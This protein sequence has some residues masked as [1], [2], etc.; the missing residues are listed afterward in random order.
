MH[1][2]SREQMRSA[3]EDTGAKFWNELEV[4][5]ELYENREEDLMGVAG[6][7]LDSLNHV[8]HHKL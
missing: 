6:T 5:S 8:F 1:Y 3:I 4:E 2:L 7:G